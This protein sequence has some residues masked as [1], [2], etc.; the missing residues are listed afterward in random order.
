MFY[1]FFMLPSISVGEDESFKALT[2]TKGGIIIFCFFIR[3]IS[4]SYSLPKYLEVKSLTYFA[5]IDYLSFL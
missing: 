3:V 2:S 5:E 4:Y 1:I